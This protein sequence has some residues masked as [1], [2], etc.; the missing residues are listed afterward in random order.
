[1]ALM[2]ALALIHGAPAEKQLGSRA[3]GPEPSRV[4]LNNSP[5][6]SALNV[7]GSGLERKS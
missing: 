5:D 2:S 3:P 6:S 7:L 4:F 1:M